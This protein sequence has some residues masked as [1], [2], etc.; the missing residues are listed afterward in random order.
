M[1]K[2][3]KAKKKVKIEKTDYEKVYDLFMEDVNDQELQRNFDNYQRDRETAKERYNELV[4]QINEMNQHGSALKELIVDL[5]CRQLPTADAVK[6]LLDS[7]EPYKEL[8]NKI[9]YQKGLMDE[10]DRMIKFYKDNSER[11]LFHYWKVF[12]SL[13]A[14]TE[15][16]MDWKRT[17]SDNII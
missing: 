9:D 4:P 5:A 15:P 13:D 16:W 2:E 6:A 10:A 3:T 17:Y 11:K 1:E 12:D 8:K 7:A 14:T